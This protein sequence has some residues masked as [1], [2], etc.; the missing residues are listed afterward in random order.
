MIEMIWRKPVWMSG[1]VS[2][3]RALALSLLA[4]AVVGCD[5]P[6][7][8]VAAE[9]EVPLAEESPALSADSFVDDHAEE[10]PEAEDVFQHDKSVVVSILGYHR[11]SSS[12]KPT[13]MM[14]TTA[15]FREEM[16]MLADSGVAVVSMEDF[17]AWKR[18]EINIPNPSVVITIDDGWKSVYTEAYPV[19][20]EFGF[21]FT[22]FIYTNFFGGLG[23]TLSAEQVK[24]MIANGMT[25]GCHSKSHPYVSK[26][27]AERQKGE[28]AY[29]K[30]LREE[31][32]ETADVLEREI[33]VRPVVYAYPGGYYADDMLEAA[34][35][36]GYEALFTVNPAKVVFDT[37][38]HEIHRY[39]V[40]GDKPYTFDNATTFG[41][42][43]LGRKSL[44]AADGSRIEKA[45]LHLVPADG[46][47]VTDRQPLVSADLSQVGDVDPESLVMRI[48]G[49]GKVEPHFDAET[50]LVTY[51]MSRRLRA[52]DVAVYL[53]WKLI[54]S[55]RYEPPLR[56]SFTV[57]RTASLLA[58]QPVVD[59]E[60]ARDLTEE[61]DGTGF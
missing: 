16:Q 45:D 44:A 24:E 15:R 55:D 2:C 3:G 49:F 59:E 50:K 29:A 53:S 13:D 38:N 41:G 18:G 23:K 30:F 19:L 8:E 34:N 47:V 60:S 27:R 4:F 9:V 28:E 21:P 5:K 52:T 42:I 54:E 37:P 26:V 57:D 1:S 6:S 12:A 17:L 25:L 33:G 48:S 22:T 31:M 20:K 39:V 40:H 43:P 36:A 46:E 35:E 10:E 61:L 51:K 7:D 56:W 11:F 32:V 14:T 58:E